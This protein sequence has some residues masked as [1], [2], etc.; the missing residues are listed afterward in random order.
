MEV[1]GEP[2]PLGRPHLVLVVGGP[3]AFGG[4]PLAARGEGL[5]GEYG[6]ER[7]AD[8][9]EVVG[10]E[11]VVPDEVAADGHHAPGRHR[12]S[13]PPGVGPRYP[14]ASS[15]SGPANIAGPGG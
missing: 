11:V 15:D 4:R 3:L 13:T 12:R 1:L 5:T 10:A 14:S 6:G 7:P 2:E 9:H 8:H